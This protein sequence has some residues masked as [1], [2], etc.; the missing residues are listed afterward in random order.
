VKPLPTDLH[1]AR[2]GVIV[3]TYRSATTIEA[4]IRALRPQVE[5]VGG[6]LLIVDNDSSDE[7]V[8]IARGLGLR[9][10]ETGANL[11]FAGGCNLGAAAVEGDPIVL[12][13]PDTV[14]DPGALPALVDAA[15]DGALGP[16]GGRAHHPDGTYD[17][18]SVHGRPSLA[19][20]LL[21]ASGLSTLGRGSRWFDPEH[22][23][24]FIPADGR[25][26]SVPAISG[27]LLVVP[28][29]LWDGL[30]GFDERF[31]LYGED[32]DLSLRAAA[33]GTQPTLVT[34]AGYG[35]LG[36]ASSSDAGRAGVLLYRGKVELYRRHLGPIASRFAVAALQVGSLARG[37]PSA[38]PLPALARRAEPWWDLFRRRRQWRAG[39]RD[40]TPGT[41]PR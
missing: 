11:G 18:R 19:G 35:H 12:V 38:L 31:F 36:R 33:L 16:L 7:T 20:A 4:C 10:L 32:V 1:R 39:Y 34:A 22:G 6:E 14:L 37:L 5:Q 40:H 9:V 30:D 17:R 26:M 25:L 24:A 23:P 27:A 2:P 8:A 15:V 41:V 28:R 3:L 21:F 29:A 13:N